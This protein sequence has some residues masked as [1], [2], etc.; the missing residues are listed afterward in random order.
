MTMR[1]TPLLV[2]VAAMGCIEQGFNKDIDAP[3]GPEPDILVDPPALVWS[4]MAVGETEVQQFTVSNVGD[5]PLEVDDIVIGSGDGYEILGPD[6]TFVLAPGEDKVVD[7]SFTPE[8]EG[9]VYGAAQVLSNDPDGD[10]STVDLLGTGLVPNIL[11]EPSS[12][13]YDSLGEGETQTKAFLV[14]NIGSAPLDVT[15]VVLVDGDDAFTVIG[16]EIAFVLEPGASR[17][18][19]VEFSPVDDADEG[20]V[21]VV[22]ND[23]DGDD[24]TVQ[25]F[26]TGLLPDL[27]ITPSAYDF[28]DVF[29][30]CGESVELELANEGGNDLIIDAVDYTSGGSLLFLDGL[31]LPLTLAPGETHNVWVDYAPLVSGSDTGT[32]TVSSNDPQGDETAQQTGNADWLASYTDTFYT[33]G[34]PPVDVLITIDQSCSMAGDNTDDVQQG[35]PDFVNELQQI[36]DWQLMLVTN[37]NGCATQGVLDPTTPNASDIL[38]NNAFNSA[39]DDNGG[40]NLT[41]SLLELSS[42]A[43]SKT[44]PGNCNDGFLRPGALLHIITLSD[45][46]EQSGQ[47]GAYWV[48]Q[49][50]SYVT[51]P[52]LLKVSGVLDLNNSCGTG[53]AVYTDAI[54]QTGGASLNICN[55]NWGASFTD[56]ASEVLAGIQTY[57]LA[58]Q[59]DEST[60]VVYVNGVATTDFTYSASSNSVTVNSP[61]IGEYDVVDID[62]SVPATCN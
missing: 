30:P 21:Q 56:I 62:Y 45:E 35:F 16:P 18:V 27:V 57:P 1:H 8:V 19:Q 25:L 7:I 44:G 32:L 61:P 24:S 52:N 13:T 53:A 4:G 46:P 17:E 39:H 11:V 59:A 26:G 47:T 10:N 40:A 43:L 58:N 31:T 2:L 49:F 33:P 29:L 51:D 37:P 36:S 38:V 42:I 5:G 34:A 14:T 12:L 41:E 22:S 3:S 50:E 55:S 23:P 9:E 15:D 6:F 60:I 48:S 54:A 28:G 20:L